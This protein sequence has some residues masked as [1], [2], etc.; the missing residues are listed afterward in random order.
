VA[1]SPLRSARLKSTHDPEAGYLRL[2]PASKILR[3]TA[4]V[5]SM[6]GANDD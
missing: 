1:E 3:N 4:M 2:L 6:T 5:Y